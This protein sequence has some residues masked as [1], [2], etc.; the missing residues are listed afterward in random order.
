VIK[1]Y[2]HA[3]FA[4]RL[5]LTQ[6]Q[7]QLILHPLLHVLWIRCT[8]PTWRARS[9]TWRLIMFVWYAGKNPVASYS[10]V[11]TLYLA[12]TARLS[13][14]NVPCVANPSSTVEKSSS[15]SFKQPWWS[16]I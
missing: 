10:T 15:E 3:H 16:R 2:N 4:F 6:L 13:L 12:V 9:K 1:A 5:L 7:L 8:L 14:R 11:R